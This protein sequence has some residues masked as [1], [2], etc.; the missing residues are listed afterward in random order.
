MKKI[1]LFSLVSF[2]LLALAVSGCSKKNNDSAAITMKNVA[3][4]YKL[5]ALTG[6][7]GGF[8]ANLMDSVPAC[9]RDDNQK[10]NADS[11]YQYIDAGTQ[12]DS[13]VSGSGT[14]YISGNYFIQDTDTLIIKSFN[15]SQLVL[16]FTDNSFGIPITA[17]E[18]ITKI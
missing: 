2:A 18:T 3:G 11:T 1:L 8:S 6:T 17:T 4:T 14:W 15:G 16:T 9:Q 10:F 5:T 13:S 12:C 7:V